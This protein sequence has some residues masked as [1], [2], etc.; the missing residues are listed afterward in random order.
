LRLHFLVQEAALGVADGVGRSLHAQLT[1]ADEDVGHF[2]DTAFCRLHE[3]D[4]VVS[5]TLRHF[6]AA[7]A[8]LQFI[9]DRETG[10]VV[11]GLGDTVTRAQASV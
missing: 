2:V 10:S 7:Y 6:H 1:Q 8:G 9:G 3:G 5:V 11:A 4:T